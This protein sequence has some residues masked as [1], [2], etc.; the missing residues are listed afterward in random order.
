MSPNAWAERFAKIG[1][2]DADDP[3]I[4][5]G[6]L[7]L[8]IDLDWAIDAAIA[9]CL[10]LIEAAGV[11]ATVFVTHDTP[12][13]ARMRNNPRIELGL[14]PDFNPLLDGRGRPLVG[15]QR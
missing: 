9:M 5:E 6:R 4:W 7:F 15:A 10:D 13:L 11:A 12:L 3:A 2:I 8:T 1:E 14:H